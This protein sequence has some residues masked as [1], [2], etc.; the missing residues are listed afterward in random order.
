MKILRALNILCSFSYTFRLFFCSS[1]IFFYL[2]FYSYGVHSTLEGL[3]KAD[4]VM[5]FVT[6][7]VTIENPLSLC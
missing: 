1:S 2:Q 6:M 7:A 4:M 5:I 3:I